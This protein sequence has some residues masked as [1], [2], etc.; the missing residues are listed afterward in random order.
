MKAMK[1]AYRLRRTEETRPTRALLIP[2]RDAAVVL[3]ICAR[4]GLDAPRIF[5]VA[6]GFLLRVTQSI[7]RPLAGVI[8]LG[9]L[10]SNLLLPIDAELS[11]T[12]LPDEASALGGE[13]G[14][15]FLPEGRVLDFAPTKPIK[16]SALVQFD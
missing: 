15:I 6:D 11:P 3:D 14:L 12:L 16:L 7:D 10:A 8:R 4:L 9:E 5:A 13:R 1:V 2:V